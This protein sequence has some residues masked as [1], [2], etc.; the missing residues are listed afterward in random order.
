LRVPLTVIERLTHHTD[1]AGWPPAV[2]YEAF[3]S[4]AKTI[5]GSLIRDD[6]LV[7]EGRLQ[8][9]KVDKL[10]EAERLETT[11]ERKRQEAD[12][13]LEARE[14]EAEQTRLRAEQKAEERE[15]QVEQ[16]KAVKEQRIREETRQREQAAARTAAHREKVVTDQERAAARTRIKEES[17][18][19]AKRGQA[20]GAAKKA[21]AVDNAL[22]A[23]KA[24][25]K[26]S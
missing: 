2:A 10:A 25:R 17:A 19:L 6:E 9:A 5:V 16:E 13:R 8:R 14:V 7:R 11:A 3:E 18:A 15:R 21:Q 24:H 23:K 26:S 4:Q 20:L 12:A 22:E 1:A